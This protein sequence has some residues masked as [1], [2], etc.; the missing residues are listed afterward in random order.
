MPG[1]TMNSVLNPLHLAAVTAAMERAR[2]GRSTRPGPDPA[3]H[4]AEDGELVWL[5]R[6]LRHRLR[7]GSLGRPVA[8]RAEYDRLHPLLAAGRHYR[9]VALT[10]P[11]AHGSVTFLATYNEFRRLVFD[12]VEKCH[13]CHQMVP[14]EEVNC[15]EDL[16]D[17][18]LQARDA[19]GGSPRFRDSAAH[20]AACPAR[21]D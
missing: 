6:V 14:V 2:T 15:L 20:A 8:V 7:L 11:F 3:L 21:G 10:V 1:T 12:L 16:G 19:L 9:A 17:F 5:E 4:R 18:L 13:R